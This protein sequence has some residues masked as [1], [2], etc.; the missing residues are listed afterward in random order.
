MAENIT[1]SSDEI[2][3]QLKKE[4]LHLTLKPGQSLSENELCTRFGVSRTPI[5]SVLQQLKND[6]LVDIV[7]YKGT[8]VT[9]LSLD[10][11]EQCIYMRI[12]I[13]SMVLRDF[14]D[15]CTPIQI[16][17]VRYILRM[18]TVMLQ[19][20]YDSAAFSELDM[21]MHEVWFDTTGKNRLW[22]IIQQ[23]QLNY[24][25]FRMLDMV[26]VQNYTLVMAEHQEIFDLIETHNRDQVEQ[27][28]RRHLYGGFNRLG[29]R[30]YT[31][32][33]DYFEPFSHPWQGEL[34]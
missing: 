22:E 25:R 34:K 7:P 16:E 28:I 26:T 29:E 13:E 6:R 8:T 15:T 24:T 30:I 21:Q 4:I 10:D 31:E 20:G 17:K 27:T 1:K 18:Q 3:E 14:I 11:I 5:R 9:L 19:G 33:K 2:Y 12:A 23:Q 32:F